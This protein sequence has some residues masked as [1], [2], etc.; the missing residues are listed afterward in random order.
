[1]LLIKLNIILEIKNYKKNKFKICDIS[2]YKIV[3][4]LLIKVVA[5]YI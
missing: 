2:D 1:M 3:I 4:A 5:F